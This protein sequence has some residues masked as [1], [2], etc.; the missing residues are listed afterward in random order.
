M[1]DPWFPMGDKK[2]LKGIILKQKWATA[3]VQFEVFHLIK[4]LESPLKHRG[5]RYSLNIF[6]SMD[7]NNFDITE[8]LLLQCRLIYKSNCLLDF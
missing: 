7:L 2:Y 1:I 5:L 4:V 3:E 6:K 8:N